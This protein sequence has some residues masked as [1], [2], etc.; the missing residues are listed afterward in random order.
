MPANRHTVSTKLV[1]T[2]TVVGKLQ[3]PTL[4]VMIY[5]T[6]DNPLLPYAR[7][8]VAFPH[9]IEIKVNL[10][11]VRSSLRGLKNKP[12]T[13]RPA[14]ITGLVR[15]RGGYENSIVVTYALT[16]KVCNPSRAWSI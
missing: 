4:R 12:G 16:Q 9:Q 11:E 2:D 8:D 15:K 6:S 13:T 10:D 3:D 5:C 7:A 1:L 14:D